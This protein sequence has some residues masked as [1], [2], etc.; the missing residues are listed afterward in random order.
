MS[1]FSKTSKNSYKNK[2]LGRQFYTVSEVANILRFSTATI[3]KFIETGKIKTV[4]FGNGRFRI[5]NYR[6]QNL[7]NGKA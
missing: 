4:R 1:N 6:I 7:L 2:D 3:Y 5:P